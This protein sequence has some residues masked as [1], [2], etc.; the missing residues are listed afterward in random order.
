M[1]YLIRQIDGMAHAELLHYMNGFE[2]TVFPPLKS[3]HLSHGLWW[4]AQ[5]EDGTAIG[6]AGL[7]PMTPFLDVGFLKRSYVLPQHRGRGLQR[8]FIRLREERAR[9]LGMRLLVTDVGGDNVSSRLNL[10]DSGYKVCDP[11]QPWGPPGS[12]YFVKRL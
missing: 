9:D 1:A 3:K 12:T 11:E 4:I 6:F 8:D 2:P 5:I 7:V 10:E